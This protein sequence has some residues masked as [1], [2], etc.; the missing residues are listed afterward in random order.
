MAAEKILV[1]R[2]GAFGDL[3]QAEG[4]LHDLREFHAGARITLLTSPP[5]RML[6][7]RCPHVDA[8]IFDER[9]PLIHLGKFL[10]LRKSLRAEG[11]AQAYD[12]QNSQRTATY[13]RWILAGIPWSGS[14]SGRTADMSDREAYV[15]QLTKA[16]V[17][18]TH[19]QSPDV[20]WMAEDMT[21]F[22]AGA[23]VRPGYIVLIPGCAAKHQHKR[24]P[25]YRELACELLARGYE[26]VTV[27]GPDEIE[28]AQSIP[29]KTLLHPDNRFLNWFELAGV[30]KDA[31]FV[32]GND[33]G[34][35][36]VA[37]CLGRP[38]LV[39]FGAHTA[40]A[41]TGILRPGFSAIEIGDLK[42][43]PVAQVLEAILPRLPAPPRA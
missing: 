38:G 10:A 2:H 18:V 32:V 41:R 37:S 11:F 40:A 23:G 3:M 27:P 21:A 33:T 24:W 6:M 14:D 22:L 13:R 4:A 26:V 7:Q 15:L 12:L 42:D 20:S 39:L 30:L 1:I 17:P 35:S 5:F 25:C 19:S 43:L 29:G 34:P 31:A 16:G 36:H 8:L 9:A 28:L